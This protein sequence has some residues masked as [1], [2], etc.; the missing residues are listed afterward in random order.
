MP[1]YVFQCPECGLEAEKRVTNYDVQAIACSC[2]KTASRA[3]VNRIGISGFARTPGNE[4]DFG[5][6]Y[7]RFREASEEI[8]DVASTVERDRGVTLNSPLYQESKKQA[9]VLISKGV[10]PD[11]L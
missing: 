3:T 6:D 5:Q 11:D 1:I 2:G 8:D 7:R 9:A 4:L 10:Q